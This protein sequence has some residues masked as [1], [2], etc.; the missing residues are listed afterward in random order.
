MV[1]NIHGFEKEP[2]IYIWKKGNMFSRFHHVT[3]PVHTDVAN[4]RA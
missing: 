3:K 4:A 2:A 1:M